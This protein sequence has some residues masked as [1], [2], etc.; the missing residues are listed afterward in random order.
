MQSEELV[1]LAQSA[2]EDLKARD[3]RVLD[4]QKLTTG[5][6]FLVV[7]SGTSKR[8]V[9]SVADKVI[10]SAKQA[11]QRP[12]AALIGK[13]EGL[14]RMAHCLG[15]AKQQA[16]VGNTIELQGAA[17]LEYEATAHHHKWDVVSGMRVSFAKLVCPDHRR[18]VQQRTVAARFRRLGQ[19]F[20]QVGDLFT[21]PLVDFR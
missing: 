6:D 18:I 19:A 11:G 15:D 5:A 16:N 3:I 7:A 1:E 4:V 2:L 8:H 14:Y 21:I 12:I 13:T 20:G 9:Q 10:E 17:P